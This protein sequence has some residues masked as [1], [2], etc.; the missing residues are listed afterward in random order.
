MLVWLLAPGCGRIGFD[1]VSATGD[2]VDGDGTGSDG[3]FGDGPP[4]VSCGTLAS[5]CGPTGTSPCCESPVVTGGTYARSYDVSG[6]GMYPDNSYGA[7]VSTFRLD[8]YEI[9]VG[10]FRQFVVAGRGT[11]ANPPLLN[12]GARTLNGTANQGGWDPSWNGSLAVDMA[13]LVAAVKCNA[14]YQTWTDTPGGNE[15][16]PM[17]CITWYEALAF[18]AW[19]DGFVPTEAEWNYAASGGDQRAY[20]WSSPAG[21]LGIDDTRA[22]YYVDATKQCF[23]DGVNGCALTDL[24]PVGSKPAGDGRWGQSDLGGNVWEW[25]L[26]WNASP[27]PQNPCTDCANLTPATGR[28]LRGGSFF[29]GGTSFLRAGIRFVGGAAGRGRDVGLRCARTP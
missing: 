10:R 28:V 14:T 27:Y 19:D 1:V 8:K 21:F 11:Q 5:T 16:R 3:P 15:S 6:D 4:A 23:G 7:T 9:T 24:V 20:P 26:D 12:A 13:A 18:C 2:A 22:S 17:N 25:V 29:N